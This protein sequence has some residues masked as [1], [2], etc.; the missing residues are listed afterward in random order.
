MIRRNADQAHL[1]RGPLGDHHVVAALLDVV[2]AVGERHVAQDAIFNI[3]PLLFSGCVAAPFDRGL[4]AAIA[5]DLGAAHHSQHHV[6]IVVPQERRTIVQARQVRSAWLVAQHLSAE[7][8][9]NRLLAAEAQFKLILANGAQ[10][11]RK[12]STVDAVDL[13]AWH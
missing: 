10:F 3:H 7:V 8:A 6:A 4:A 5:A 9:L 11:Y 1:K 12:L 2:D 13:R